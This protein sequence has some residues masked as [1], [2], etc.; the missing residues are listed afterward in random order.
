MGNY[1]T[2]DVLLLHCEIKEMIS[3]DQHELLNEIINHKMIKKVL[4]A[5][6][7]RYHKDY[8]IFTRTQ[9]NEISQTVNM[10]SSDLALIAI[11]AQIASEEE[12]F[13][14]TK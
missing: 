2:E 7:G 5:E 8:H 9:V 6:C 13:R 10:Q 14:Y 4:E 3:L 11:N 1:I 12:M